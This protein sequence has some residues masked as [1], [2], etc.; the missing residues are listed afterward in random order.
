MFQ[1]FSWPP[2]RSRAR[3]PGCPRTCPARAELSRDGTLMEWTSSE[4]LFCKVSLFVK[5]PSIQPPLSL[6][7]SFSV[8]FVEGE[9]VVSSSQAQT[10]TAEE[11]VNARED[12]RGGRTFSVTSTN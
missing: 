11:T 12:E 6:S 10:E 1:P 2:A 8:L 4:N 9:F 3:D 7:L 5:T